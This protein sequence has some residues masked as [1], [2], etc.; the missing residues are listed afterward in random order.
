MLFSR[1]LKDALVQRLRDE[2]IQGQ[3]VP[4]QRLVQ[5]ELAEVY[6]VSTM[7]IRDA[8]RELEAE[9][10]VKLTPHRSA[11]VTLLTAADLEDIYEIRIT[12]EAMATR[13]ATL[14]VQPETLAQLERCLDAMDDEAADVVALVRLN[15]EF[16]TTLYAAAQRPHL[17]ELLRI[18]RYRTQHYLHAYITEFGG[19][20][21]AQEEH[22]A[23]LD[24][25]RR[26]D[27]EEAGRLM[28]QHIS[29]VAAVVI[30]YVQ[31]TA[32]G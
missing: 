29:S 17:L 12:L 13:L 22:R 4:G 30:Q 19:L 24:A 27:A 8:L 2:I 16:H 3:L 11:E 26:G 18:L 28:E 25:S 6:G 7:P 5:E 21:L 10:L 31:Q 9:G 1:T 23:I 20:P 15:H 32:P 14:R